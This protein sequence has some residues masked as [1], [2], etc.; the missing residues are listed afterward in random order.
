MNFERL[1]ALFEDVVWWAIRPRN[2]CVS[3]A[4]GLVALGLGSLFWPNIYDLLVVL[5]EAAGAEPPP[6]TRGVFNALSGV[7]VCFGLGIAV[8]CIRRDRPKDT[9]FLRLGQPMD[10][11]CGW[12][13]E[14]ERRADSPRLWFEVLLELHAGSKDVILTNFEVKRFVEGLLCWNQKPKIWIDGTEVGTDGSYRMANSVTLKANS[15]VRL[16][17]R[18]YFGPPFPA[19]HFDTER[20]E[21]KGDIVLDASYHFADDSEIRHVRAVY[22]HDQPKWHEVDHVREPRVLTSDRIKAAEERGWISWE[23][24]RFALAIPSA[25]RTRALWDDPSA[26]D[27]LTPSKIKKLREIL[28]VIC[29]AEDEEA[30]N[31]GYG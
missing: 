15:V 20:L 28:T 23:D 27:E 9:R 4:L 18:R 8:F 2:V 10:T 24:A 31:G 14:E 11:W 6:T 21:N 26:R 16:W 29:K 12:D 19:G 17:Y 13:T 5:L 7:V 22:R 3:L 25:M 30:T 1:L